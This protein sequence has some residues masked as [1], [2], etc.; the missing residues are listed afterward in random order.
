LRGYR[1]VGYKY[2]IVPIRTMIAGTA[3]A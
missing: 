2:S 1:T 3:G